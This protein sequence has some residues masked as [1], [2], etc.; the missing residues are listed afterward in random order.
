LLDG[1]VILTPTAFYPVYGTV[2]QLSGGHA[3]LSYIVAMAGM[4]FTTASYARMAVAFPVANSTYT[5][6]QRG[7]NEHLDS[8]LGDRKQGYF[9]I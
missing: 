5:Y 4:L 8:S 3:A 6:V 2:Q 9:N 7:L 1:L